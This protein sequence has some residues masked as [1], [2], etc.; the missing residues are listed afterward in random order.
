MMGGCEDP[1]VKVDAVAG[2]EHDCCLEIVFHVTPAEL[3]GR[4]VRMRRRERER[5]A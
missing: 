4:A 3:R 2:D 5:V 1:E